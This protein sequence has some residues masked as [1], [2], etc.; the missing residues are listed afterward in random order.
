VTTGHPKPK[1]E[2]LL[3]NVSV[4][5]FPLQFHSSENV[6]HILDSS[7]PKSGFLT[8]RATGAADQPVAESTSLL[9]LDETQRLALVELS[10]KH[11]VVLGHDL[12][13]KCDLTL[14]YAQSKR[15]KINWFKGGQQIAGVVVDEFTLN[16][17]KTTDAGLYSCEF[18]DTANNVTSNRAHTN[19]TVVKSTLKPMVTIKAS[20][21]N[22]SKFEN[23]TLIIEKGEVAVKE[24]DSLELTCSVSGLLND[25]DETEAFEWKQDGEAI[26]DSDSSVLNLSNVDL[27][28]SG[29]Y[30]CMVNSHYQR[31][32]RVRVK[33]Y[34]PI[35]LEVLFNEDNGHISLSCLMLTGRPVPSVQWYLNE[36][37]ISA[38]KS[39]GVVSSKQADLKLN[40]YDPKNNGI[41][42][43]LAKNENEMRVSYVAINNCNLDFVFD[44]FFKLKGCYC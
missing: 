21:R 44:V 34:E 15:A 26:L 33:E 3:N 8:C 1:V 9:A 7:E 30:T 13:L 27:N 37:K 38:S 18:V 2:W 14:S 12:K 39:F 20:A 23:C 22:C 16:A 35:E 11:E 25:E 32:I 36:T 40:R 17:A 10:P 29:E 4:K 42:K 28:A 6:L 5:R 41:Y 31:Q 24:G 19:V 43:C